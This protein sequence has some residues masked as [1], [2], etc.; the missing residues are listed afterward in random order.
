MLLN[1]LLFTR[2]PTTSLG[3]GGGLSIGVPVI[4]LS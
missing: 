1:E 3:S 2:E 4:E